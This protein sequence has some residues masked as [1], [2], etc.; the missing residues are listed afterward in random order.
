MDL[1]FLLAGIV[2]LLKKHVKISSKRELSG[3]PVKILAILYILPFAE[4]F[5]QGFMAGSKNFPEWDDPELTG[6]CLVIDVERFIVQQRNEVI[7]SLVIFERELAILKFSGLR[8]N[9]FYEHQELQLPGPL[10]ERIRIRP[11]K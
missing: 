6:F 1:I 5:I 7:I 10:G 9:A 3:R 11:I 4:S 8:I 2:L